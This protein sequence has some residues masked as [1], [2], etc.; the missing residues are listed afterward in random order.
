MPRTEPYAHYR[1]CLCCPLFTTNRGRRCQ[2]CLDAGKVPAVAEITARAQ[3]LKDRTDW[4]AQ[5]R[6]ALGPPPGIDI[7]PAVERGRGVQLGRVG[8]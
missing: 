7:P 1:R 3:G 2:E 8:Q 6:R 5:V 4:N